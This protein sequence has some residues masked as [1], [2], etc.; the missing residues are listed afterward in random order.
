MAV[1]SNLIVLGNIEINNNNADSGGGILFCSNA[2]MFLK[3]NTNVTISNNHVKHA[4]GGICVEDQCMQ[5]RPLCFFQYDIEATF[6]SSLRE[7]IHIHLV[8]NIAIFAGDHIFGGS[9]DFCYMMQSKIS[10]KNYSDPYHNTQYFMDI[11]N[12]I[13]YT[14]TSITSPERHICLCNSTN[15]M[16][17]QT[18]PNGPPEP[19]SV[20]PGEY[21]NISAV[22]VG[23][24]NGSVPGTVYTS[25]SEKDQHHLV[26]GEVQ[27]ISNRECTNLSYSFHCKNDKEMS[28]TL[29]VSVQF[30]GDK[31]FQEHLNFYQP[32]TVNVSI[33]KCPLGFELTQQK[34]YQKCDCMYKIPH[35]TCDI[36]SKTIYR[37]KQGVWIGYGHVQ[38]DDIILSYSHFCSPYYCGNTRQTITVGDSMFMNQDNQCCCNRSGI[39]CGACKENYSIVLGSNACEDSC[40]NYYLFL[41][42]IFGVIG[43]LLVA[44][45]AV[46]NM[47]VTVGSVNGLIFYANVLQANGNVYLSENSINFLTPVLKIFISW[48]NLDLGIPTCFFVGMDDYSKAW[49]QFVFPLYI[50]M[51]TGL[52]IYLSRHF[53]FVTRLVEKNGVK[54]LAT[55]VLLSYAKM[56]RAAI[57]TFRHMTLHHISQNGTTE[58]HTNCWYYDCNIPYLE[59]KH[60]ALFAFGVIVGLFLLPFTFI[61]L[62][63][64]TL[65]KL[66]HWRMFSWVWRLKPFFDAYAGPY[67]K[68]ARYWTGLLCTM[69]VFIFITAGFTDNIYTIYGL[70]G[71]ISVLLLVFAWVL[72]SGIY[73]WRWFDVQEGFLLLNLGML[74]MYILYVKANSYKH[75]LTHIIVVHLFVG[76]AFILFMA[77]V[78]C[79]VFLQLKCVRHVLSTAV[80]KL[81]QSRATKTIEDEENSSDDEQFQ[82]HQFPPLVHHDHDREPLLVN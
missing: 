47:T 28:A 65:N 79:H 30:L 78:C 64:D 51:I 7:S 23:Q 59:G 12:F 71:G 17:C 15:I 60:A 33:K 38:N 67:I 24:M 8:N 37:I 11:F 34:D 27:R 58:H 68:K 19:I 54:V 14:N 72:H 52:I 40:S 6:N 21:F 35:I 55:L 82:V 45:I 1:D 77:V 69:R 43:L 29:V 39:M 44:F 56:I 41:A 26:H 46:L 20:Y 63:N 10:H 4:G 22:A 2:V 16:D 36:N 31:S 18:F 73:K 66:S 25:F 62:F 3:P 50:W 49:L 42:P 76:S 57:T 81:R 53:Y 9:V 70:S 61:L 5:S 75:G 48:M 80:A 13:P 74:H 32:L